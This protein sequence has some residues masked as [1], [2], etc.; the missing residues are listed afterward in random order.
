MPRF[1][2]PL[3]LALLASSGA[4]AESHRFN[5]HVTPGLLLA[6]AG[7]GLDLGVGADWQFTRGLGLDA[8]IGTMLLFSDFG[9]G[10]AFN[11]AVGVR[12]R[13]LDDHQ[14]Y[15]NDTPGNLAGHL[16]VA[17]HLGALIGSVGAG[18]TLDTE[19]T[20][21]FSVGRP[22][23]LG[24]FIRPVIG[25]GSFGVVGGVTVG[26][27]VTFGL[28]PELGLDRD[29]DGVGDERDVC[30]ETPAGAEVDAR[31]CTLIPRAM[32]L[33][34]IF[35]KLNSADIEPDSERTLQRALAALRDN[36]DA[37]VEVGG[38]TDDTGSAERN[39][40]LSQARA[41]A[42]AGWLVAHGIDARRLTSKGHGSTRPKVKNTDEASRAINRRIEFNRLDQ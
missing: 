9:L 16:S 19:V 33:E 5:L 32:V 12:L 23:Q 7:V 39:D 13:F 22:V 21:V 34:G 41:Q 20:Y 14:G 40:T 3:L 6:N 1:T 27:A 18:L 11:P 15:A 35:F 10:I 25:F 36:P 37:R 8:R 42:V 30:P 17:P 29:G 26:L 38:H 24:P 2:L 31:G 28:G 4:R